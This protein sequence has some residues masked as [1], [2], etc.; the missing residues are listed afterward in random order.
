MKI[1][2]HV[3]TFFLSVLTFV[4]SVLIFLCQYWLFLGQYWFCFCQYSDTPFCQYWNLFPGAGKSIFQRWEFSLFSAGKYSSQRMPSTGK[5]IFQYWACSIGNSVLVLSSTGKFASGVIQS[6]RLRMY[7]L[8]ICI[9]IYIYKKR[10]ALHLSGAWSCGP[11]WLT[12]K[13]TENQRPKTMPQDRPRWPQWMP[14]RPQTAPV[15]ASGDLLS[16]RFTQFSATLF[17]DS[18]TQKLHGFPTSRVPLDEPKRS[19]TTP[20]NHS[21]SMCEQKYIPKRD[22]CP[23][24][25][26]RAFQKTPH[27]QGKIK[28]GSPR[29]PSRRPMAPKGRFK[30]PEGAPSTPRDTKNNL[31]GARYLSTSQVVLHLLESQTASLPGA[32]Y[33]STNN[34]STKNK[35]H[36]CWKPTIH[37]FAAFLKPLRLQ[38]AQEPSADNPSTGKAMKRLVSPTVELMT[39]F[40]N[41]A[42]QKHKQNRVCLGCSF[43]PFRVTHKGL[44]RLCLWPPPS[45]GCG[46]NFSQTS[47]N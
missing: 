14:K 10:L 11:L 16:P 30:H 39:S 1:R 45:T 40:S 8:Y 15:F 19:Q 35:L 22:L 23:R 9:Y 26:P 12:Q 13:P 5:Y 36:G 21:E 29:D 2:L 47:R 27:I 3:L 32:S 25:M 46:Q 37:L 44:L 34:W 33:L 4:G 17:F 7:I 20:R 42:Q 18:S 6:W 38:A 24:T 43:S 28:L 41:P 31:P